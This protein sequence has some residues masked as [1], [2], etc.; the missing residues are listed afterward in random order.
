M[1]TTKQV[2]AQR[3]QLRKEAET[4]RRLRDRQL[5]K[6]LRAN[7]RHAMRLRVAQR[8]EVLLLCRRGKL[9]ARERV[10]AIRAQHRAQA[11]AEIDAERSR[12]RNACSTR[13]ARARERG[14]GSVA[15]A[16]SVLEQER[17]HQQHMARYAK[18][19]RKVSATA[20]RRRIESVTES[21]SEVAN[22]IPHELLPVWRSVKSRIK[23]NARM[24]RT[25]VFFHWVEEHA[26]EVQRIM[27]RQF[28]SDVDE[29]V[30]HE[31]QLRERVAR[32]K[33][34]RE[35]TDRQLADVPF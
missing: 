17:S 9:T 3:R 34:Y 30:R 14:K 35:M 22:N 29:L 24:S 28:E 8:K 4:A 19:P 1:P 18:P 7:L 31:Q 10:A 13:Q 5:L 33:A 25:E 20:A 11:A 21:D 32:P 6:K 26:P 2:L 27:H 23:G 15:R 16:L 12:A